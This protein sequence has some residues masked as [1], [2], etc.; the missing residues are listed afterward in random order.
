MFLELAERGLRQLQKR[1]IVGAQ[2]LGRD[3]RERLAQCLLRLFEQSDPLGRGAAFAVEFG[4]RP[5]HPFGQ[6]A[7]VLPGLVQFAL[8]L[9]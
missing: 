8:T 5:D 7:G 1:L 3:C 9:G 2:R 6:L 4:R